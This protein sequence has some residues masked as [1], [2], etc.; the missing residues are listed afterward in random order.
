MT[1]K[2]PDRGARD[3]SR[4]GL[5]HGR[6]TREIIGAFYEVY[7]VLG[8]G[9]LESVYAQALFLEL[10]RRGLHVQREVMIDV[11]YK[12]DRVGKFRADM[13]VAYSVVVENKAS[14]ALAKSDRDQLLNY[15]RCSCLEVG[16]L[17][18]FGPRPAFRRVVA[19]N[20]KS[21]DP[22]IVRAGPSLILP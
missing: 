17:L 19:E 4:N 9:F 20:Q 3:L 12:G 11:Y 10:T 6:L 15:L 1:S 8:Y 13:L 14:V 21:A 18:H 22:S 16:L 2:R 7:N 5:L